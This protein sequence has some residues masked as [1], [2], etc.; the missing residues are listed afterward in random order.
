MKEGSASAFALP[1]FITLSDKDNYYYLAVDSSNSLAFNKVKPDANCTFEVINLSGG[2][3]SL[4]GANGKTVN[5]R[6]QPG[7]PSGRFSCESDGGGCQFDVISV[8]DSQIYLHSWT[9]PS[10]FMTN[11]QNHLR[12][13]L[14]ASPYPDSHCLFTVSAPKG[15]S[16]ET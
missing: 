2:R 3:I 1:K 6:Y 12:P 15:I 16:K 4:K 8:K 7:A 10:F 13:G 5:I 11:Y 14:D 9:D